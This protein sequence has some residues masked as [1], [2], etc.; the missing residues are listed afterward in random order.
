MTAS[1]LF[2]LESEYIKYC[3]GS[4]FPCFSSLHPQEYKVICAEREVLFVFSYEESYEN[5]SETNTHEAFWR[6]RDC[7]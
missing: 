4:H 1:T 5:S 3:E 7:Q 2:E 6:L